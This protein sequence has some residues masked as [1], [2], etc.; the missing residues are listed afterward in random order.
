MRRPTLEEVYLSLTGATDRVE[1]SLETRG[2]CAPSTSCGSSRSSSGGAASSRS[3]PSCSRSSSSC[4]SARSTA[5]RDKID[6]VKGSDYLLAGMLGYGVVATAFAGAGDHADDPPRDGDPQA[7]CGR[8]RSPPTAYL[9]GVLASTLLVFALE[10][11]ALVAIGTL[12][13]DA[14][15]P[16][17]LFSLVL[18]L[19]LGALAFA[20]MGIGLTSVIRSAEGSSAVVNAIYLPM[21]FISGAFFSQGSFPDFLR[22]IADVLPLTYFIR[23]VRDILV[24]RRADLGQP[25]RGRGRRR[26]GRLRRDRGIPPFPLG[27]ARGLGAGMGGQGMRCGRAARI[28]RAPSRAAWARDSRELRHV[29]RPRSDRGRDPGARRRACRRR[30]ATP[31]SRPRPGT[32]SA[33]TPRPT[34]TRFAIEVPARVAARRR[35]P[36]RRARRAA[37]RDRR[38][39]G[40]RLHRRAARRSQRA[41]PLGGGKA[42]PALLAA[43]SSLRR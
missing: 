43:P 3:S 18:A 16:P 9:G 22:A 7:R 34:S 8:R 26:L 30:S 10:A 6:G 25:R 36:D 21:A 5:T 32:R 27:A 12:G 37:D 40:A 29:R 24:P 13:F 33:R 38:A 19:L 1:T 2:A 15:F 20:A 31:R 28:P 11:V 35:L 39:V 41:V 42:A 17:R 14:D 23:L 4:C